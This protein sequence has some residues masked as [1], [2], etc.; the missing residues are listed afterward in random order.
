M[1]LNDT[2]NH[3]MYEDKT[4]SLFSYPI[5]M[6]KRFSIVLQRYTILTRTKM[7]IYLPLER[8]IEKDGER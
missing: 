1:I 3:I 8:E 4:Y 5:H 2:Y 7:S 6:S